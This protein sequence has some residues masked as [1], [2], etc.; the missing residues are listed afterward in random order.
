M[1]SL[2]MLTSIILVSLSLTP[3]MVAQDASGHGLY[4]VVTF[5]NLKYDVALIACK[6]DVIVSIAPPGVDPHSY[7]LTPEN[8]VSL[9]RADVIVSTAHAPFELKI[10]ELYGK[11]ELKGVLIEIPR[12]PGIR[13]FKNPVTGEYNFHMPIYD[14]INFKIFIEYLCNV[15]SKLR[16]ECSDVYEKN[17]VKVLSEIDSLLKETPK[18][19]VTIAIDMPSLQYAISWIGFKIKYLVIKE[20][21]IPATPKDIEILESAIANGEV[22]LVAV[23]IPIRASASIILKELAERYEIPI[24]YVPSPLLLNSTVVKLKYISGEVKRLKFAEKVHVFLS[25]LD[26]RWFLTMVSAGITYGFLGPIVAVRRLRFLATASSHAAL[27]AVALAVIITNSLGV[28]NEYVWSILISLFLIYMVGYM[29]Y[30]GI[31]PDTATSIFVS[32]SA[33]SSVIAMYFVLTRYSIG[34][35]LWSI[36]LGDPLLVRWNDVF[37]S[38]LIA[39]VTA[40]SVILTYKENVCIG[41]SR[42]CAL[43]TGLRVS[44]YDWLI[45]T[46]LGLASI[47]MIRVVGFILEHVLILLPVAIAI[48]YARNAQGVLIMSTIISV[49]SSVVGLVIGIV[50]NQAPSGMTG[51]LLLAIYAILILIK[52]RRR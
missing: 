6:D 23:Q 21:G 24:L 2:I 46:L 37:F 48:L 25:R 45:Y 44:L 11:G 27:L 16:P 1:L 36:I 29:I 41:I 3:T 8:V 49:A 42:D 28:L 35:D 40:L 47:A 18:L 52:W 13:I 14:P 12:I 38:I 10:R 9:K 50:V 30:R 39:L 15:F 43:I 17:M 31:S 5:P 33:S 26:V 4:I 22:K 32:L 7:Q 51:L 20:H 19:N 34:V